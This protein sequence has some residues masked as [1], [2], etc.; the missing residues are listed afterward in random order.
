MGDFDQIKQRVVELRQ[1]GLSPC[2]VNTYLRHLKSFYLWQNREWKLPWLK[3]EE[4]I[5]QTLSADG[6]S[7]LVNG[8]VTGSNMIR[9]Q[10][11]ALTILDTGLRASEVLGLTKEDCDIDNMVFKVA[12]KGGKHRLVPFSTELRKSL[13]RFVTHRNHSG[14][15]FYI[16]G[17]KHNTKVT[18]RNLERYFDKLGKKLGITGVRF[19]PHTLRHTFATNWI[20]RGGDLFMLSRVLGHSNISTTARYLKSL[21]VA[22]IAPTAQRV[23]LLSA[24]R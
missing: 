2:S 1:K 24:K 20:R 9:T 16:F 6:V 14:V 11:V 21:G 12:G 15:A 19:S 17:T 13:F 10:L 7:A 5:I 4:K 8:K 23:S 18:V 3:E 22:D